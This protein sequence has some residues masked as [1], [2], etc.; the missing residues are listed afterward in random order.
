M[1]TMQEFLDAAASVTEL[2]VQYASYL[3]S[4]R[5]MDA[6][7]AQALTATMSTQAALLNAQTRASQRPYPPET[8]A[9]APSEAPAEPPPPAPKA[10]R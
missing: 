4:D 2:A 3:Q 7:I 10:K 6:T 8:P 9:P 1:A 5:G